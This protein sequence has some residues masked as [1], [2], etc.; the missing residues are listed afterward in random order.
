MTNVCEAS[1][2]TLCRCDA[3]HQITELLEEW[4]CCLHITKAQLSLFKALKE[5]D[6]AW[7]PFEKLGRLTSFHHMLL[8][9]TLFTQRKLVPMPIA[10][11]FPNAVM[12]VCVL[13]RIFLFVVLAAH[14]PI[15]LFNVKLMRSLA[16]MTSVAVHLIVWIR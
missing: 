6:V 16:V 4:L 14:L 5:G 3:S 12:D 8:T 13:E 2:V 1:D 7:L 9:A 15:V 10:V 11:I